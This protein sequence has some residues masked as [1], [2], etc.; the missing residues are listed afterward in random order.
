M[1]KRILENERY[2]GLDGYP[3]LITDEEF[4]AVSLR[5][6]EQNTYAPCPSEILPIRDKAVCALCG[7]K[8]TR[9]TKSHGRPCWRCKNP[10][11]GCSIYLDDSVILE[12]VIQKLKELA[13]SP[14][15]IHL[16]KAAPASTDA[17]RIENELALCFNRADINSDYM[18]TLI[19]AAA[20]ERYAGLHDPTPPHR[21]ALL[22]QRLEQNPEDEEVLWELFEAVIAQAS[23]GKDGEINLYQTNKKGVSL[24]NI[25][26]TTPTPKRV[27]MIP[28]DP[29]MAERDL[30]KNTCGSHPIVG[31][32]LIRKNS[33]PAT[34]LRSNTIPKK[35]MPI[36]IG[37]WFASTP[38]RALLAHRQEAKGF[39]PNDSGLRARQN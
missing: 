17:M 32:P 18:K 35:S 6:R 33:S 4:L 5:R 30:R 34:R 28:A 37:R 25:Q 8:M 10:E 20:A 36:R 22:Q 23:I 15:R 3:R 31:Y 21:L 38:M 12:R 24:M 1:V 39:S 2:L 16:P 7:E 26:Q 29:Q 27:T 13:K 19:M 14:E 9:D 11:C